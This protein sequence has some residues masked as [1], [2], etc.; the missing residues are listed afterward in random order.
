MPNT[1]CFAFVMKSLSALFLTFCLLVSGL[2]HAQNPVLSDS[3]R[4]SLLTCGP[5][6][7][8]YSAFGHTG[9]R[10]TDYKQDFDVVFN[11]GTFDFAQP[12]FYTN[13][14]KGK[15]RYMLAVE[16]Y[17][18]FQY[19]YKFEGR[20]VKEQEMLLSTSDK[21]TV[22]ALLYE[23]AKPENCEYYYDF[24]WDN[25]ATRPRD[26]F[27]KALGSRL[28]YDTASGNFEQHKT[29]HDMLRV[30]VSNRP[31]I[32]YGFDLI[33]GMP[34]EVEASPRH[35][36]FLPEYLSRYMGCG[37]VDGKPLSS[38]TSVIMPGT[39]EVKAGL[40][41]PLMINIL[42]LV[43]VALITWREWKSNKI[44]AATDVVLFSVTGLLGLLFLGLWLFTV[45]YSVP[46]NLNL[47]WLWP[48][49]LFFA[50]FLAK[51]KLHLWVKYYAVCVAITTV[52]L[53]LFW[54][55]LPQPL[56][57]AIIP[58]LLAILIRTYSIYNLRK[59]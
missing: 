46:R 40:I 1:G 42:L 52:L 23:N 15:M 56:S 16:S 13:F 29:M 47:L 41:H 21:Q 2:L 39:V 36:T 58:L 43:F 33:L 19:Q 48:T 10:V 24:F 55:W 20:E 25:C 54:I 14:I 44:F 8:L 6:E 4:I 11:Y 53:L 32:D 37:K 30:F 57:I 50:V 59:V 34:C 5:G 18:N 35:Q 28:Q 26:I 17:S 51:K 49:H 7:E 31:W 22:F 45:H 3:S 12:G 38:A 27:E 9:I